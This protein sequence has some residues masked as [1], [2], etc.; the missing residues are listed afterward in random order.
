MSFFGRLALYYVCANFAGGYI[1]GYL[2]YL[3]LDLVVMDFALKNIWGLTKLGTGLDSVFLELE[4]IN[5]FYI[6]LDKKM[7]QIQD[8]KDQLIKNR[9]GLDRF[10]S[11]LVKIFG[12]HYLRKLHGKELQQQWNKVFVEYDKPINSEEELADY[13]R[14]IGRPIIDRRGLQ[15]RLFLVKNF[16]DT[17]VIVFKANHFLS[18]GIGTVLVASSL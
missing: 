12:K 10:M 4:I 18:D 5:C 16:K 1:V 13:I 3:F 15:W 9:E 14:E 2:L 17:S 7:D 6:T 11:V 8:I